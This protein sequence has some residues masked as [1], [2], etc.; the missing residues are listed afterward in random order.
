[1]PLR[2]VGNCEGIKCPSLRPTLPTR[3]PLG[4]RMAK[5]EV[6]QGECVRRWQEDG[7]EVRKTVSKSKAVVR[8]NWERER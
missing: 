6:R 8:R 2:I 4:D 3:P 1:M 5:R 7:L